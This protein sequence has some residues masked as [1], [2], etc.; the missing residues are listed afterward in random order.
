MEA[1]STSETLQPW[2]P[3]MSLSCVMLQDKTYSRIKQLEGFESACDQ[4]LLSSI[5]ETKN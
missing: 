4:N 5:W 3:E 1:A 2:E